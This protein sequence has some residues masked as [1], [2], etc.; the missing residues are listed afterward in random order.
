MPPSEIEV[1][2]NLQKSYARHFSCLES[3]ALPGQAVPS[4]M[5]TSAKVLEDV[6]EGEKLLLRGQIKTVTALT[7][8]EKSSSSLVTFATVVLDRILASALQEPSIQVWVWYI[9]HYSM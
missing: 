2:A 6:M 1:C 9:P 8:N 5:Q 4:S 7:A 3:D